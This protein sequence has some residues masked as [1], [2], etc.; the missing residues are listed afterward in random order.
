MIWDEAMSVAEPLTCY[1]MSVM[2]RFR[3]NMRLGH[4]RYLSLG[5]LRG[6]WSYLPIYGLM[7]TLA[8]LA[9]RGLLL[10]V[11]GGSYFLTESGEAAALACL[12][13]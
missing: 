4:G 5:A 1:E 8:T 13:P 9:H 3:W 11:T 2:I 12:G 10:E 7:Q 6:S